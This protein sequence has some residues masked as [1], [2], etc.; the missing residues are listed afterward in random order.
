[1]TDTIIATKEFTV[2]LSKAHSIC[3]RISDQANRLKEK[4]LRKV[5]L[6][7]NI[8]DWSNEDMIHEGFD[9]ANAELMQN[10][11]LAIR[12]YN[13]IGQI[14]ATIGAANEQSGIAAKLATVTQLKNINYHLESLRSQA[15][16]YAGREKLDT[17]INFFKESAKN[18]KVESYT[19]TSYFNVLV[20][21]Q[22]ENLEEIKQ[23]NNKQIQSLKDDIAELNYTTKI[24]IVVDAEL[25]EMVGLV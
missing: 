25:A 14:R 19:S 13:N 20:A 11:G 12:A 24:T 7:V 16:I 10:L 21:E 4:T 1:M 5:S 22:I 9:K 3:Q 18:G 6:P 17:A 8:S 2:S 15:S 23:L